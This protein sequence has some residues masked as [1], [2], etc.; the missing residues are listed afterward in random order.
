MGI[1]KR[2][3]PVVGCF[4]LLAERQTDHPMVW[5]V[6][7]DRWIMICRLLIGASDRINSFLSVQ[8]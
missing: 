1:Q 7:T 2:F 5:R 4:A 3:V 8:F 6:R